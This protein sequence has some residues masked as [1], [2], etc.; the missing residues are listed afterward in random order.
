VHSDLGV[1]AAVEQV[2]QPLSRIELTRLLALLE[3]LGVAE[4]R[5]APATLLQLLE[6]VFAR[7]VDATGI[8][9]PLRHRYVP[10]SVRGA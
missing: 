4:R 9:M 2:R 3:H 7:L 8:T 5:N 10:P 1:L 6:Q